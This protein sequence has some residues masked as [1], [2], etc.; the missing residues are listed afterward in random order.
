LLNLLAP[1]WLFIQ[2]ASYK[3]VF[4]VGGILSLMIS[5]SEAFVNYICANTKTVRFLICSVTKLFQLFVYMINSLLG[6]RFENYL[7]GSSPN[8][9]GNRLSERNILYSSVR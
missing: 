9:F 2:G 1:E 6:H 4:L 8:A 7:C 3:E 5:L